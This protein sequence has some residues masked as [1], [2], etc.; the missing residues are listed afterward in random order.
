MSNLTVDDRFLLI[1]GGGDPTLSPDGTKIAYFKA[2]GGPLLL[3]GPQEVF[4]MNANGT[5]KVKISAPGIIN[6]HP[7]FGKLAD[8]DQDGRPDY[9]DIESPSNF[10]EAMIQDEARAIANLGTLTILNG[11]ADVTRLAARGYLPAHDFDSFQGQGVAFARDIHDNNPS[12]LGILDILLYQPDLSGGRN[13]T[14]VFPDFNYQLIGWGYASDYNPAKIS[15][16]RTTP[17]ETAVMLT[18]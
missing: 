9:I 15:V 5:G 13:P 10:N 14:D 12:V 2:T 1:G 8:S 17:R 3:A 4:V 6:V 16:G 18:V 11:S 7:H